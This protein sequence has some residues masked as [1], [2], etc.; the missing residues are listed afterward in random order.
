MGDPET[1]SKPP[2]A[3]M[4]PGFNKPIAKGSKLPDYVNPDTRMAKGLDTEG[5]VVTV[6]LETLQEQYGKKDGLDRYTR[7][8]KA[9]GFY[10]PNTEPT[11][12]SF[13]P[14]LQLEGVNKDA[15][16]KVDEILNEKE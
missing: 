13:Y 1:T 7:I 14:D 11:G 10:D 6:S 4:K 3:E 12:S 15:R 16:E 8:A 2:K 5:K 9:G